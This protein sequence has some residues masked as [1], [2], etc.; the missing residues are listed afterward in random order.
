MQVISKNDDVQTI[1]RKNDFII[2][3]HLLYI[4]S[5]VH[6]QQE[7]SL[8][9]RIKDVLN[10]ELISGVMQHIRHEEGDVENH[11]EWGE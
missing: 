9:K 8:W 1:G 2:F 4:C 6:P 11:D 10:G 7:G 3:T 5:A